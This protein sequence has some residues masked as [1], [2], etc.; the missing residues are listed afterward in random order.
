MHSTSI[1]SLFLLVVAPLP[2]CDANKPA[3]KPEPADDG[4][5]SAAP[6]P[7]T[8]SPGDTASECSE[9]EI[10]DGDHCVPEACGMGTWGELETGEGTFF[11]DIAAEEGGDGSMEAPL[12]SIQTA[13]DAASEGGGNLVAVAAGTYGELLFLG[14]DHDGIHLA[15]RCQ[16]L[17]VIDASGGD[18]ITPG[19]WL[20][21]NDGAATLS[22]LT[23]R[24]SGFAGVFVGGGEVS[25]R[26]MSLLANGYSGMYAA[27]W[28]S[29]PVTLTMEDCLVAE[30]IGAGFLLYNTDAVASLSNVVIRDQQPGTWQQPG[31]GVLVTDGA[32]LTMDGC[33]LAGNRNQGLNIQQDE[34]STSVV[35]RDTVIRDTLL[36]SSGFYGYGVQI[37]GG[38][39]ELESCELSGNSHAGL[40]AVGEE[41]RISIR[42]S[43]IRDTQTAEDGSLGDGISLSEGA[44][45]EVEN[46]EIAANR[47]WGVGVSG[48]GTTASFVDSVV[49]DTATDEYGLNGM[50]L[51]VRESAQVRIEAC[52]VEDN[53]SAG[54][55]VFD[56][57]SAA[58]IHDTLVRGTRPD[59]EAKNGFALAAGAGAF[60]EASQVTLEANRGFGAIA[61]DEATQV[62][63][64]DSII[65]ATE[66]GDIYTV[67]AGVIAQGGAS[68]SGAGLE[69]VGNEGPGL[70]A[71]QAG[72]L[73]CQGCTLSDN[74]FAGAVVLDAGSL[75]LS[76]A[77]IERTAPG[78]N[79]G[80]GIG[81]YA[82]TIEGYV[83][84][85]EVTDSELR[86][87]PI[88]GVWLAG[89]GQYLLT[90]NSIHGGEGEILGSLQRCGDAVYARDGISAWDGELGLK[91]E[92][93]TLQQGRGAGLFLDES[94]A[95]VSGNSWQ[96]NVVDLVVQGSA[97]DSQPEGLEEGELDSMELCPTYD[98]S[99]CDD[100][101]DLKVQ[102]SN[103]E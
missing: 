21:L 35:L 82:E 32:S 73:D 94:S 63:M 58:T 74:E 84:Y 4:S 46:S 68:F 19:I 49:R 69:I 34:G 13:L 15:G 80:G 44:T 53:T 86:D 59:E 28:Y 40:V 79:L 7:D 45:L 43:V 93:N 70:L 81:V 23:V 56:A 12:T 52:S 62:F 5:D 67:A 25:V 87:N 57:G 36:S 8:G 91:L 64:E 22:G 14:P 60:I 26:D 3:E 85:L 101:L 9:G 24:D 20:A 98:Y 83:P 66:R 71:F 96:D 38:A 33:E 103:P 16:E 27:N 61:D 75:I 92:G 54:I 42:D 97:C 1:L 51:L 55:M 65:S 39:L 18:E 95:W 102:L 11:V 31:I 88:A 90:G 99:I 41:T 100:R 17:V 30:N 77:S 89:E 47:A 2:A 78:S 37:T 72:A 76:D 29:V 50:G 6:E 10:R 48:E